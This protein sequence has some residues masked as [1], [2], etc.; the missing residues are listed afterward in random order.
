[1]LEIRSKNANCICDDTRLS[2]QAFVDLAEVSQALCARLS[3]GAK[4]AVLGAGVR[5]ARWPI[6]L[7]CKYVTTLKLLGS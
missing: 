2:S 5:R 7:T 6:A 4:S 1:M 3:D